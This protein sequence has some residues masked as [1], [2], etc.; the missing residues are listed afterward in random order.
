MTHTRRLQSS[1]QRNA[2][3]RYILALSPV[4]PHLA[5]LDFV[6]VPLAEVDLDGSLLGRLD[7]LSLVGGRSLVILSLLFLSLRRLT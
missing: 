4:A 1:N 2:R 7:R 6:E 5:D 3:H